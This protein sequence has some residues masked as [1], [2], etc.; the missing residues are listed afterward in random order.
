[1]RRHALIGTVFLKMYITDELLLC[2]AN[3]VQQSQSWR[4]QNSCSRPVGCLAAEGGK[5]GLGEGPQSISV[6]LSVCLAEQG[7]CALIQHYKCQCQVK[8]C[9]GFFQPIVLQKLILQVNSNLPSA[10]PPPFHTGPWLCSTHC[11]V[12]DGALNIHCIFT[13]Y[14]VYL[15]CTE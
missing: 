5:F 1:M 8:I 2:S 3:T 7:C 9:L 13:K 14:T 12:K 6:C 15:I 10:Q 11:I 4:L